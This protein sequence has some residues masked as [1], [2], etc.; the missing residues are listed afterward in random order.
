MHRADSGGPARPISRGA[1]FG[2]LYETGD[3]LLIASGERLF[4]MEPDR[5]VRWQSPQLSIDGVVVRSADSES[6][7]GEGEWDPTGGWRAFALD[8]RTGSVLALESE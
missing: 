3:Y 8:P 2:H 5:S 6:I 1:Y 7:R 4:R